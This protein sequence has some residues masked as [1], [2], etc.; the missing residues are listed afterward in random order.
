MKTASIVRNAGRI[1]DT[2]SLRKDIRVSFDKKVTQVLDSFDMN[3]IES[4]LKTKAGFNKTVSHELLTEILITIRAQH[5]RSIN[6]FDCVIILYNNFPIYCFANSA[7]FKDNEVRNQIE[8]HRRQVGR[9]ATSTAK[10]KDEDNETEM[11]LDKLFY[12]PQ[13]LADMDDMLAG[14][15]KELFQKLCALQLDEYSYCLDLNHDDDLRREFDFCPERKLV[16]VGLF[17]CIALGAYGL[18]HIF[19]R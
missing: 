19:K 6:D 10:K 1:R 13:L 16:Y 3:L 18:T 11:D 12:V 7:K 15:K 17:A 14:E 4:M 2:Q 9:K 8:R 5:E